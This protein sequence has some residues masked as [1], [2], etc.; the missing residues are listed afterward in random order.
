MNRSV[1]TTHKWLP[2]LIVVVLQGFGSAAYAACSSPSLGPLT[3][4]GGSAGQGYLSVDYTFPPKPSGYYNMLKLSVNGGSST[5]FYINDLA[6]T[7]T[8]PYHTSCQPTGT[9]LVEVKAIACSDTDASATSSI[10]LDVVNKPSIDDLTTVLDDGSGYFAING[11]YTFVNSGTQTSSRIIRRTVDDG[12]GSYTYY[13]GDETG[14]FSDGVHTA[15]WSN[16]L[17]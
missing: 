5:T 14:T 12:G 13:F 4:T 1:V 3:W 17:H 10:S 16:G 2:L 7:W 8:Q 6:G 9:Y 11:R 15:C